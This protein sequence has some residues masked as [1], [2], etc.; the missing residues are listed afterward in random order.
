MAIRLC[1]I[2]SKFPSFIVD[3]I[4]SFYVSFNDKNYSQGSII[5]CSKY[6]KPTSEIL[7]NMS[8]SSRES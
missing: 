6:Q 4:T 3:N 1:Y 7:Q 2:K 5:L 8:V